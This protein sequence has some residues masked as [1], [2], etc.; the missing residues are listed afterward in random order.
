LRQTS[1]QG[2]LLAIGVAPSA[3]AAPRLHGAAGGIDELIAFVIVLAV[4]GYIF[5]SSRR[6]RKK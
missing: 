6:G 3:L 1:G 5:L 4:L 2:R